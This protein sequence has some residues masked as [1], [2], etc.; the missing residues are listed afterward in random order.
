MKLREVS[1]AKGEGENNNSKNELTL[2]QLWRAEKN[3]SVWKSRGLGFIFQVE[4]HAK[5][6]VQSKMDIRE[7]SI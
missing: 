6:L 4:A 1:R 3:M 7:L 2:Q 5:V